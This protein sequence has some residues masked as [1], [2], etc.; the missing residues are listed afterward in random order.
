MKRIILIAIFI[1]LGAS[2]LFAETN[3]KAEVDKTKIASNETI[4]YKF[5][6][7]STE[8][9]I[10][11]PT[12]PKFDGFRVLSNLQSS[13]VSVSK[14]VMKAAIVYIRILAPQQPG[15]LKIGPGQIK[16][17]GKTIASDSFDIEVRAGKAKHR[18]IVPGPKIRIIPRTKPSIPKRNLPQSEPDKTTL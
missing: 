5:I 13:Q 3:I 17:A 12:L 9:K 4:T 14:G 16:I 11:Q 8:K 18:S 1:I 15:K 2:L 7:A 6:I 10:P